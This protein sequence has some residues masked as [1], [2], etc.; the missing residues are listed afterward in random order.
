VIGTAIDAP[1]ALF[2]L[3]VKALVAD[4][5]EPAQVPLGLISEGFDA[6]DVVATF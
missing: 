3:P 5:V 6:G 4:P 1:L 2:P